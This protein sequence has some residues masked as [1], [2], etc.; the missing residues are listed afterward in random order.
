[1][2]LGEVEAAHGAE[3][4]PVDIV[5]AR[6]GRVDRPTHRDRGAGH[7]TPPSVERRDRGNG[8]THLVYQLGGER[9]LHGR[10]TGR[11]DQG[12]FG[13][14]SVHTPDDAGEIGRASSRERVC[15]FVE[16]WV[17]TGTLKKKKE[18]HKTT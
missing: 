6:P 5:G 9:A 8:L 11:G 4:T 7:D 17:V 16:S 14:G 18:D 10:R 2:M 12:G 3:M 1:M 13:E 15:Q